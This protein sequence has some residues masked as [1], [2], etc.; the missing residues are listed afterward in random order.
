MISWVFAAI[1]APSLRRESKKKKKKFNFQTKE[2]WNLG[3]CCNICSKKEETILSL[4]FVLQLLRDKFREFARET[5]MVGQ[6]RVDL[7]NQ[8]IDELIEAGHAEA[9]TMAEWKD[10][11]N[12]SWADLLELIDTRAQ[13]LATSYELLK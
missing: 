13:L 9:A 2:K 3:S 1:W 4:F 8:T 6:E 10:G 12:E 5:G 7:V 11:I